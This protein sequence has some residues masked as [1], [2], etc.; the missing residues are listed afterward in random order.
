MRR[1]LD[2]ARPEPRPWPRS[3]S[4]DRVLDSPTSPPPRV[5]SLAAPPRDRRGRAGGRRG[6]VVVGIGIGSARWSMTAGPDADD[7]GAGGRGRLLRAAQ[8]RRRGR[9]DEPGAPA[10][11]L[12]GAATGPTRLVAPRGPLHRAARRLALDV[13]RLEARTCARGAAPGPRRRR[14]GSGPSDVP[15]RRAGAPA[16]VPVQY[17][18]DA[19]RGWSSRPP[20]GDTQVA[21]V[22]PAG[23]QPGPLGHAACALRRRLSARECP[24]PTIGCRPRYVHRRRRERPH[25]RVQHP[26]R[27]HHRLR[28]QRATP[29][30]STPRGRRSSPLVFEGSVTA[31]GALMNTTEVENFPGFRDGI[32]GPALMDEMRGPGRA[33]RRRAGPRRRGRGRPHR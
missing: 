23:R 25:V 8:Q 10:G 15:R 30:P 2:E 22:S 16:L 4:G 6:A 13:A 33:L 3:S 26:Q 12:D 1:L 32:M 29:R 20:R 31:G 21:A 19:R 14:I 9:C 11:R 18:G 5:P 7:A 28:A 17:G 27:H 24:S